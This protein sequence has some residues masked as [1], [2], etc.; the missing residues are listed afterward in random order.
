MPFMHSESP[1]IHKV[2][3]KLF[4]ERRLEG[5]LKFELTHKAIIDRFGRYPHRNAYL[6]RKSTEEDAPRRVRV[7]AYALF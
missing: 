1:E 7:H 5:N 6:E 4:S 2:A 3:L